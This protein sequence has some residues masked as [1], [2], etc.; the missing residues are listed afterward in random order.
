MNSGNFYLDGN[1]P[2]S[3]DFTSINLGWYVS[4]LDG[5]TFQRILSGTSTHL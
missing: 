4:Q 5:L 2:E 1:V 3:A